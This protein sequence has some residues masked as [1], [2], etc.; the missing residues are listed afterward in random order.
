ML[1]S[2]WNC[3]IH[4]DLGSSKSSNLCLFRLLE[5]NGGWCRPSL[6]SVPRSSFPAQSSCRTP[7]CSSWSWLLRTWRWQLK[8][9]P[10]FGDQHSRS[11]TN[12][13]FL[14]IFNFKISYWSAE[15]KISMNA[16]HFI[17]WIDLIKQLA[18]QMTEKWSSIHNLN[19]FIKQCKPLPNHLNLT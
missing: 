2:E 9:S 12:T 16:L 5:P 1:C 19:V 8:L 15:S 4:L 3:I 11:A 14:Q 17:T 18:N 13:M 7:S 10:E 6:R